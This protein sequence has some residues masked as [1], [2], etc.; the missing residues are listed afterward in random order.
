MP[1]THAQLLEQQQRLRVYQEAADNV[2]QPWGFSAPAPVLGE[3]GRDYQNRLAL[4]AQN[5]L[6]DE[7][8]LRRLPISLMKDDAFEVMYPR[9]FQAAKKEVDNP[10]TV[11]PGEFRRVTQV[12]PENGYKEIRFVGPRSF[13]HDFTRIRGR[14]IGF[15]AL[16]G[17][18]YVT[19]NGTRK[20]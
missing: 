15:A 20:R 12:N 7:H 14:V 2:F 13:T 17:S 4:L 6:P 1:M 16:D 5:Q 8:E 10:D 11:P 19:L 9:F 18:G 3:G